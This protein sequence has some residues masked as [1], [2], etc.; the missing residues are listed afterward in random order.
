MKLW[1]VMGLMACVGALGCEEGTTTVGPV[2]VPL[3]DLAVTAP[4]GDMAGAVAGADM[5]TVTTTSTS[6]SVTVGPNNTIAYSPA[7]VAIGV[8]GS[9]TWT[10]SGSLPHSVTSDTGVFNSDI[11][12]APNSFSFTF[13]TA[14]TFPYHCMV[15]G[16]LMTGT[17]TVQ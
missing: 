16:T 3:A 11:H 8:G 7:A 13:T 9:V 2:A 1:G 12:M 15:H 4:S 6:A 10:W 17:V 14:G 5:V